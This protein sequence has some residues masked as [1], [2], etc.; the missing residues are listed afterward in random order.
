M[1][2]F[3]T[4]QLSWKAFLQLVVLSSSLL[5]VACSNSS[6]NKSSDDTNSSFISAQ[7]TPGSQPKQIELNWSFEGNKPSYFTVE[8]NPDGSS[9]FEQVDLNNDGV[10]DSRDQMPGDQSSIVITLALHLLSNF[11]N[12]LYYIVAHDGSGKEITKSSS[13]DLLSV[14]ANQLIGYIKASNAGQADMFGKSLALAADGNTLVVG[15]Y[16]ESSSAI[17]IGGNQNSNDTYESGSVYVFTRNPESNTWAQQAYIKASNTEAGDYFGRS[18]S[19]SNSGNTLAVGARLEDSNSTGINGDENDNSFT[20]AGA[21]YLFTRSD[22]SWSQQTYLKA[23]NAGENDLFGGSVALSGDGSTLV[24]GAYGESSSTS[25]IGGD[26]TNNDAFGSGAVYVFTHS[27]SGWKQQAYLKASNPNGLGNILNGDYST[28]SFGFSLALADDGNTLAVGA[29]GEDSNAIGI[30]GNQTNNEAFSS[31]AVYIFD[32][33]QI[34]EVWSQQAY[35]KASNTDK[36]D[37]FGHSLALAGDGNT[38]AIGAYGEDGTF[39][40]YGGGN[41][42]LEDAG[43]VY[44]FTRNSSIWSQQAYLKASNAGGN[45]LFGISVALSKDGNTLAVGAYGEGS[46][47][48]GLEGNQNSNDSNNS[49]AVY[50]FTR[51]NTNWSQLSYVKAS[52]TEVGDNFG[53]VIALS[54]DGLTLAVGASKESS[55]AVGVD[56]DQADNSADDA[57]AVYLY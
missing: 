56:A 46:N 43:A 24:V 52:N 47:A 33:D 25:G 36:G 31:G 4:Q 28:D 42:D 3:T 49:G 22:S 9:G 23:S 1:F 21:V 44:V 55:D 2:L 41:N 5:L 20:N 8:A 14:I 27:D 39:L 18:V 12:G 48:T 54:S 32:R 40:N 13:I 57:G 34:S 19:L 16:G 15:A 7:A 30:G 45:D 10:I 37:S 53:D 11:N 29:N 38:L 50:I 26:Q 51:A 35:V 17:G 6:S